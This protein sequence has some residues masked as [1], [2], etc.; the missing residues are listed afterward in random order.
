M[1]SVLGPAQSP[2][3]R[4]DWDLVE[5]ALGVSLPGD[6]KLLGSAYAD[7]VINDDLVIFNFSA[8]QR[9][10][11]AEQQRL[12][13]GIKPRQG[14]LD[15]HRLLGPD[16]SV[17]T[18]VPGKPFYPEPGGLL[19]WGVA[20]GFGHC[21]WITEGPPDKWPIAISRRGLEWWIYDGGL[22]EF[23]DQLFSGGL[24]CP[25]LPG[26]WTGELTVAESFGVTTTVIGGKEFE[27]LD[28]RPMHRPAE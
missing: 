16:G 5:R 20:Q 12:L 9:D 13:A 15:W 7:L 26:A 1:Q 27:T 6:Y 4:G 3:P 14:N 25:L 17:M 28:M 10:P 24:I 18:D 11:L 8:G 21:L 19:C 2:L 22:L 23:L